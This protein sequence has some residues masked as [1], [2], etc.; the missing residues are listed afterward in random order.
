MGL[1]VYLVNSVYGNSITHNLNKM[2]E[3]AGIYDHLWRPEE[4]GIYTGRELIVP[5]QEGL[6]LLRSDPERFKKLN[7][8]NGWGTYEG[9]IMFVEKYLNACRMFPDS[10]IEVSR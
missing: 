5:L 9:L 3:E 2:A 7:P 4:I 6:N 10:R 1:D 8:E